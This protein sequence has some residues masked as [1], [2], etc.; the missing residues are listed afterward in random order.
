M[1]CQL[2]QSGALKGSSLYTG[3]NEDADIELNIDL[4]MRLHPKV[5]NIYMVTDMTTTGLIVHQKIQKIMPKYKD[6]ITIHFLDDNSLAQL[7]DTVSRLS[8]DS[9]V[10][11]TIFQKDREGTFIEFSDIAALLSK[12]SRVPVYG[13]WDFYLGFGIVGGMLTSGHA[14]G[15]SAGELAVRVLRG[16][17]PDAIPV[18]MKSPNRYLFDFRQMQRFGI[19]RSALPAE[20][21][22]V[23]EPASFYEV[24]KEFVWATVIGSIIATIV[25]VTLSVNIRR[26]MAAES[27]LRKAHEELEVRIEERTADLERRI[28]CYCWK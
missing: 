23:N 2:V 16:E 24:N 27:L 18:I 22:V 15:Q 9:L 19:T 11:L 8:D 25:I 10:F 7:A 21:L 13:L 17:S 12:N 14:Q 1:R 28:R 6:K 5:R 26:R 4:M 3:V 20:S